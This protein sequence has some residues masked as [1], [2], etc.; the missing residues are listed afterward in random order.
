MTVHTHTLG[1]PRIGFDREL[2]HALERH[3]RGEL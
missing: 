1:F 3:W 2:K